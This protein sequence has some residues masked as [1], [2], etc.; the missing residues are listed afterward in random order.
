MYSLVHGQMKPVARMNSLA[1]MESAY[2]SAGCVTGMTTVGITLM[3]KIVRTPH[4]LQT[5]S[6]T[7][8][9][10]SAS[11]QDGAVMVTSTVLMAQMKRCVVKQHVAD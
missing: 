5:P 8:Q 4:V 2:R 11:H 9:K 3:R 7:A 10:I 6:S 1:P